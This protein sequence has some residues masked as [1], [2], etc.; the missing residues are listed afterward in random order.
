MK[1]GLRSPVN[2][3]LPA[4]LSRA[5]TRSTLRPTAVHTRAGA[6][7]TCVMALLSSP[8]GHIRVERLGERVEDRA[9][10]GA[11]TDV[12]AHRLADRLF[13]WKSSVFDQC[14]GGEND[15]G[16]AEAAL[17]GSMADEGVADQF[18]EL[19]SDEPLDRLDNAPVDVAGEEAART[20][21]RA[22][23]ERRARAAYLD[24][25]GLADT[26]QAEALPQEVEE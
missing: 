22:V 5:S 7:S 12:P 1:G 4:S 16:R 6:S 21:G 25:A 24:L 8:R 10:A 18:V 23:D 20:H 19:G 14:L 26:N 9:V 17:H 13:A 15:P 2:S 3:A 11:A